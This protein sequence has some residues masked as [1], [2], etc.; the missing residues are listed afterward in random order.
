MPNK[1]QSIENLGLGRSGNLPH[2]GNNDDQT[3]FWYYH[4]QIRPPAL[5]LGL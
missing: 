5:T 1:A 4:S 3:Q 2:G